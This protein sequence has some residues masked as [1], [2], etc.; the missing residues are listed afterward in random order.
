MKELLLISGSPRKNGVTARLSKILL[1]EAGRLCNDIR[2][3]TLDAYALALAPC[4]H[5]GY[6]KTTPACV[7]PDWLPVHAALQR[8]DLLVIA[9]PVYVLGFPAPLKALFDRSQQ[10][11]EAKFVLHRASFI[12]P[13]KAL[14]VSAHGSTDN[15]GVLFMEEQ[16]KLVFKV[17]NAEL[18]ATVAAHNTDS[19]QVDYPAL[20]SAIKAALTGIL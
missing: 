5:C 7:N 20:R 10:Y 6:C 15:R 11:F 16:L 4:T 13:K 19:G 8:S 14:L 9:S 2:V 1:E 17:F 12:P 3:S 18:C